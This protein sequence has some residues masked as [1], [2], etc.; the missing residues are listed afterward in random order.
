[1]ERYTVHFS[2]RVQGVGFRYS[3]RQIAAG[4]AVSGYVQNLDDGRVLLVVEGEKPVLDQLLSQVM[5][6]LGRYIH[7]HT[8]AILPATGEFGEPGQ[9]SIRY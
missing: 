4:R 2:G 6:Q 1:M 7:S 3:A 9:I 5:R 8:L